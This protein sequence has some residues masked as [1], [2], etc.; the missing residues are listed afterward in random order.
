VKGDTNQRVSLRALWL[1]LNFLG[2]PRPAKGMMD[3]NETS[4]QRQINILMD[5]ENDLII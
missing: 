5:I 2:G 4:V 1:G 3:L